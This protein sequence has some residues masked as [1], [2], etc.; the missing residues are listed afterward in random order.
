MPLSIGSGML[1]TSGKCQNSRMSHI[2]CNKIVENGVNIN[3]PY[4]FVESDVLYETGMGSKR[5]GKSTFHEIP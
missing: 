3:V 1:M 5:F 2:I 4:C